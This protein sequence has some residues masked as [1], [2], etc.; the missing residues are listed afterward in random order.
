LWRVAGF[1]AEPNGGIPGLVE[2]RSIGPAAEAPGGFLRHAHAGGSLLDDTAIDQRF[3]EGAL[4]LGRPALT[5]V[6]E[7]DGGEIQRSWGGGLRM[8]A[9]IDSPRL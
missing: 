3:D 5:A 7:L 4:A 6:G 1:G 8:V 2:G 9:G